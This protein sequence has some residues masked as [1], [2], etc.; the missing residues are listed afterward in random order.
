MSHVFV[1]DQPF[2]GVTLVVTPQLRT[3][4]RFSL[5]G[6][7]LHKVLD[8]EKKSFV[9]FKCQMVQNLLFCS[10]TNEIA[11]ETFPSEKKENTIKLLND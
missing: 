4:K 8:V 10:E 7:M 3:T 5:I 6:I 2:D 9:M 11:S 1:K